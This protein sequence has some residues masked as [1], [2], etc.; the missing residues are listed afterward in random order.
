[1]RSVVMVNDGEHIL[2][3]TADNQARHLTVKTLEGEVLYDGPLP[4]DGQVD[5]LPQAV[6]EKVDNLLKGNRIEWQAPPGPQQ[7]EPAPIA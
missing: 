2:Q 6:Q 4:E 3:L 1:M 5:G 7:R